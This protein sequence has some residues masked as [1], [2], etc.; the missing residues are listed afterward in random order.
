MGSTGSPL[1]ADVHRWARQHL[2]DIPLNSSS[3]G[4][5]VVGAFLLG[6]PDVP[7]WAGELSARALGVRVESWD[8]AGRLVPAGEVGELVITRPMPSMPLQFWNDPD[9]S[10]YRAAYFATY[11]GAWRHG[12]WITLTDRGSAVLHGRSDATLNR[13]GVRMGSG[14]IYAVTEA[15]AGIEETLVVGIERADGSYWMPMFVVPR[16]GYTVDDE[17]RSRVVEA[18]R[19]DLSPRHVPDEIV[20][21]VGIPHTKTGKKLE[22]P[23]KKVLLGAD[24]ASVVA[25]AAVDDLTLLERFVELRPADVLSTP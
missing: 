24:P 4:T 25:A 13:Q 1:P 7:V 12:D 10:R 22:V 3:G 15:L 19:R 9:G 8:A 18:I 20:E 17:L 14:D 16:T 21:V 2:G 11:P 5:D 6:A 23:V